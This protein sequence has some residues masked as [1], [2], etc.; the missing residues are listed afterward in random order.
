MVKQPLLRGLL[1]VLFAAMFPKVW[2][3]DL[4]TRDD[5]EIVRARLDASEKAASVKAQV[6][7]LLKRCGQRPPDRSAMPNRRARS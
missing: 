1:C 6:R 3:P 5:R 4:Q 2:V 7:T